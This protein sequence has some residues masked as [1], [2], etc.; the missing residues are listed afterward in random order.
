[1]SEIAGD[2][3]APGEAA[4]GGGGDQCSPA[5]HGFSFLSLFSPSFMR[6]K[7]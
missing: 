5:N 2:D 4:H 1:M 7:L 6:K 3:H